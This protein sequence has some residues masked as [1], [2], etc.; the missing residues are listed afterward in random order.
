MYEMSWNLNMKWKS[1][2]LFNCTWR[3]QPSGEPLLSEDGGE[4]P[5]DEEEDVEVRRHELCVDV[6]DIDVEDVTRSW[7]KG[8][9]FRRKLLT[10]LSEAEGPEINIWNQRL[11]LSFGQRLLLSVIILSIKSLL[12]R[13]IMKHLL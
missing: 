6:V 12:I 2:V 10:E 3:P 13:H 4:G 1:E 11:L 7:P 9:E 8:V 5:D